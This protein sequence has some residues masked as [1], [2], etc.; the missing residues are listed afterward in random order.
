MNAESNPPAPQVKPLRIW[1][2]L[3]LAAIIVLC[4]YVPRFIEG[5][6][7]QYWFVPIFFPMV[8][9]ALMLIWWL[10]G[11]RA[12]GREKLMGFFGFNAAV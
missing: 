5:A 3:I 1:P 2:A 9:S 10:V 4:R 7:S 11:S 12:T 6:S 8:A